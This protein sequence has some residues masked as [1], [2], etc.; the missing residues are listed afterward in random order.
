MFNI[1][2]MKV[3]IKQNKNPLAMTQCYREQKSSDHPHCTIEVFQQI[4]KTS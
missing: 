4:V 1:Q 2:K 3:K